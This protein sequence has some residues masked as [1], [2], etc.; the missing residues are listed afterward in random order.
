[1]NGILLLT[2]IL[3]TLVSLVVMLLLSSRLLC[4]FLFLVEKI[5]SLL[6]AV[7]FL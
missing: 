3:T 6:H 4:L 2:G 1:M 5:S 7:N